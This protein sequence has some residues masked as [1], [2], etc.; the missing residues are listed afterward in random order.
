MKI[1]QKLEKKFVLLLRGAIGVWH[2]FDCV[3]VLRHIHDGHAGDFADAILQVSV[4]GGYDVALVLRHTIHQT[5][6]GIRALVHARNALETGIFHNFQCHLILLAHFLQL[7][8]HTVGDVW[9]AF[10]VQAVHHVLDDV[11]FIFD[12]VV[13]EIRVDQNVVWWTQLGVVLEEE[14][15]ARLRFLVHFQL[16]RVDWFLFAF[17]SVFRF[18]TT[19]GRLHHSVQLSFALLRIRFRRFLALPKWKN[20][21]YFDCSHFEKCSF[22][23][24]YYF[25]CAAEN[26]NQNSTL[27]D[28]TKH[29]NRTQHDVHGQV[30]I[31][32]SA[33][34]DSAI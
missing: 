25:F 23:I 27:V 18:Q 12:A 34:A 32:D 10:G 33:M 30:S 8:H 7:G 14:G 31:D 16:L 20:Y 5:V 28:R 11:Q 22:T 29:N 6:I 2:S 21:V 4:V 19:V 9:D 13:H 17:G 3:L 15:R 24:F 26:E 1:H